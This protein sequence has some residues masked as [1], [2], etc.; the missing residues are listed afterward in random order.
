MSKAAPLKIKIQVSYVIC[1]TDSGFF[2]TTGINTVRLKQ[3][4]LPIIPATSI[5]NISFDSSFCSF[6]LTVLDSTGTGL[7]GGG[8]TT[9]VPVDS[10]GWQF[11][12]G[13]GTFNGSIDSV[14]IV[15]D[16]AV[17]NFGGQMLFIQGYTTAS[18]DSAIVLYI[19]LPNGVIETGTYSTQSL[20]PAKA[21][22]F[23]FVDF[24]QV[25]GIGDP[26]Y[27]AI[28]GT[29]GSN[30]TV[31][32][33]SYDSS[34]GMIKGNFSGKAGDLNNVANV[35]VTNGSFAAKVSP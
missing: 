28:P 11:T 20:P 17:W 32:I 9:Q 29:S 10:T 8:D 13:D 22:V 33:T 2:A 34:T 15:P 21:A 3:V 18:A 12:T 19:Y 24:D 25:T 1:R 30:I 27:Q 26:V 14:A 5:F 4:G 35:D 23:A 16:T 7:G 6:A 31:N